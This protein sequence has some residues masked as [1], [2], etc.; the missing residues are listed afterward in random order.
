M[1][2]KIGLLLF[3]VSATVF[4]CGGLIIVLFRK[5]LE[6][7]HKIP[8]TWVWGIV[9]CTFICGLIG[10]IITLLADD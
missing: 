5:S 8:P 3:G 10:F 4:S 6:Q 7:W 1:M 9:T 2:Y